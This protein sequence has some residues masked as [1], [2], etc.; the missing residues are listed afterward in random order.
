T[1]VE[2]GT[3][4]VTITAIPNPTITTNTR[5]ACTI[6]L[7]DSFNNGSPNFDPQPPPPDPGPFV[8]D[9]KDGCVKVCAGSTVTYTAVGGLGS[10]FSWSVNGGSIIS[11]GSSATVTVA[12]NA[13][14]GIGSITL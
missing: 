13:V 7:N 8:L 9:D 1:L 2:Q 4:N 14:V 5:V 3:K 10:S 12:W 6:P 11:G